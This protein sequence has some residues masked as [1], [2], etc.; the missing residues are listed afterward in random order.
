MMCISIM[1]SFFPVLTQV[2]YENRLRAAFGDQ[3]LKIKDLIKILQM[4]IKV[5]DDRDKLNDVSY[6]P[7]SD[8]SYDR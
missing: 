7:I 2:H 1:N 3:L 4:N 5:H 6:K 8:H